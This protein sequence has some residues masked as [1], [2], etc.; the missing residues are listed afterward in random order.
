MEAARARRAPLPEAVA[1]ALARGA[2]V[3]TP[4]QRSAHALRLAYDDAQRLS[5]R[6][7]WTP[8]EILPL[9]TWMAKLWHRMLRAGTATR[10]L[11][12][13]EQEHVLWRNLIEADSGVSALRSADSLA[14]LAA[15]A[16]RLLHLYQGQHPMREIGPGADTRAFQQWTRAFAR[17]LESHSYL[18]APQLPGRLGAA[19]AAGDLPVSSAGLLLLDFDSISPA[20]SALFDSIRQAGYDVS[21][22][23]STAINPA[24]PELFEASDEGSELEA[25]ALWVQR[26]FE[27]RPS[28]SIA[29]VVPDLAQ[30]RARIGRVFTQHL[31]HMKHALS[32]PFEFSL[33]RPLGETPLVVSALD[34]L[35]WTLN[36]LPLETIS[37][38]L[39][40]PFLG[41]R[42]ARQEQLAVAEMDAVLLRQHSLLRPELP[43]EA[44][45]RLIETSPYGSRVASLLHRLKALQQAAKA[46]RLASDPKQSHGEW[47]D[48]FR[49]LLEAA[50]WS[51]S[52]N[53][54]TL[55]FQTH[56]RFEGALD[57]LSTLDFDGSH[58]NAAQALKTLTRIV[59]QATFAPE[60]RQAP[61]QIIGP[62]EV[63]GVPF[64]ALWFL[65]AGDLSWPQT[66]ATSPLLPWQ[67]QRALA[68]PG[69]DP[70]GEHNL[71]CR[72]TG[73]IAASATQAVF[74]FAKHT[75]EGEQRPSP[76]LGGLQLGLREHT[77]RPQSPVPLLFDQFLEDAA[78]PHPPDAITHGGA[79]LLQL[80]AACGFRAFA[81]HRLH[82]AEPGVRAPGLDALERGSLVH[83]V[84]EHLWNLLP[85]Q[86][87]LRE[88]SAAEREQALNAGID[89][90]LERILRTVQNSWDAAY[91]ELQRRRLL[92]LLLPWLE[93]ELARPSFTVR[94]NEGRYQDVPL[95]PLRLSLRMD[96]VDQTDSGIVI[97]DY[98]TGSASPSQ[99]L[100]TRPD[101]PQLPL[102][103]IL[104]N[105]PP[106]GVAF[107][108]L[109]A[110]NDLALKGFADSA[111]VFGKPTRMPLSMTDQ[112]DEWRE[113]LT[114]L[115][116]AFY[117]GEAEPDP[118]SYPET[119][120]HCSQRILCRLNL[121]ALRPTANKDDDDAPGEDA[122]RD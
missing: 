69:A 91:V 22:Q 119:C 70:A 73:R 92:D 61:V 30:R 52:A 9:D 34:L 85:S 19:L 50:G 77:E 44:A 111:E 104:S 35:R 80:Q 58:P 25:A 103:A 84:M 29:V 62:L 93:I 15:K 41:G 26:L 86:Q 12:N 55:W 99:W 43:L 1:E 48:L 94:Q 87:Q 89:H 38:L 121:A 17:S 110:G 32:V 68:M 122:Y 37:E 100:G 117:E 42:A 88:L 72:L 28:A 71:A 109:R 45:I 46:A 23:I 8:P 60:S 105:E 96:R 18:T 39:L 40:S 98:K 13:P 66:P 113:T 3:L 95:G 21:Q 75:D 81:E 67:W 64:D 14:E 47:A 7:P 118:K 2:T 116:T 31:S 101:A 108:L 10:M 74:S 120:A 11:L 56:R 82:S 112:V 83:R 33:G 106:A 97:L 65:G 79:H 78:I 36:P 4:N 49:T 57:E 114:A 90:A 27:E 102:Y 54:H 107:A 20:A 16:W 59:R 76:A 24:P 51:Q 63:G 53:A 6:D 5:G 115:A